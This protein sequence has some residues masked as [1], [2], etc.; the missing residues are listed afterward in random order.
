M[1]YVGTQQ[2]ADARRR[3]QGGTSLSLSCDEG[4]NGSHPHQHELHDL[5]GEVDHQT[6]SADHHF[7]SAFLPRPGQILSARYRGRH[8]YRSR[9]QSD[10]HLIANSSTQLE[11]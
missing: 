1:E 9:H 5:L 3:L 7:I 4:A 10:R 6:T 2:R 8:P 11:I